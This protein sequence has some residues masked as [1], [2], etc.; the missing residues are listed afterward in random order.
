MLREEFIKLAQSQVGYKE[1]GNNHNKYAQYF[2]TEKSKGGPY[3]WFNGK[4]QNV[5]WCAI[6]ICWLF[7]MILEPANILGSPDKVRQWLKFPRPADNCAAGCPYLWSYLKSRFGTVAK[8]KGQ[9]GDVIFFNTSTSCAH[10]G[11]IEKISNGKYITIEGNKNNGVARGEYA[12]NS[13][14]IYGIVR[15]NYSD[16]EPKEVK[17][18]PVADKVEPVTAPNIS[19][20]KITALAKEVINGKYGNYPERKTKLNALGYGDIYSKVQAKVNELLKGG[21]T[22]TPTPAPAPK[23]VSYKVITKSGLFLRK[24]PPS[25]TN[26]TSGTK[27][28]A[29]ICCMGYGDTFVETKRTNK[30]SYGTY[31]GKSGWACNVYLGK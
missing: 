30:W 18:E 24:S 13:T 19:A 5:S 11:I 22:S 8:D 27:A 6:F 1:T 9:P 3:P 4:K 23:P 7:V 15:P 16:I 29:K 21:S 17:P 25:D 31:K 10:V 26:S 28:G 12:F 2:D 14:K 20:E